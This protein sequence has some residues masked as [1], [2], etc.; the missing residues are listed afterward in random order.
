M[1]KLFKL[2]FSLLSWLFYL[3][4][5][6]KKPPKLLRE[7]YFSELLAKEFFDGESEVTTLF[8]KRVD[9]V[10]DTHAIEVDWQS[11]WSEPIGQALFYAN[12]ENKKAGIAVLYDSSK[13]LNKNNVKVLK[14]MSERY[15]IDLWWFE[16]DRVNGTYQHVDI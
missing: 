11:K 13:S 14:F 7:T 1:K 10:T 6:S 12:A 15:D 2:L 5:P 8:R 3:V 16:V 9:I 4:F